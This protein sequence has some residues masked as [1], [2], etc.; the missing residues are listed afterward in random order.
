VGRGCPTW[1]PSGNSLAYIERR[2]GSRRGNAKI[3]D[4]A[5]GRRVRDLGDGAVG[6]WASDSVVMIWRNSAADHERPKYSSARTLN[7]NTLEESVFFRDTLNAISVM[8]NT[9]I[10][11]ESDGEWRYLPMREY[12]RDLLTEGRSILGTSEVWNAVSSNSWLCYRSAHT[13]ALWMLEYGAFKRSKIVDIPLLTNVYLGRPDY[14]DKVVTYSQ[15]R[16][17]TKIV[18]IDNVF[19]E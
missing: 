15:R 18:K 12:R 6:Y 3:L 11:Y 16:L 2:T 5:G 14:N 13:G 1:S 4:L 7:L 8:D 10:V 9:A 19:V 17:K